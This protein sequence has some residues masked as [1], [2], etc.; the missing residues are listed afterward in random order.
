MGRS[1]PHGDGP[2]TGRSG[3]A[4]GRDCGVYG[5][6]SGARCLLEGGGSWDNLDALAQLA[7]VV[8]EFVV[9]DGGDPRLMEPMLLSVGVTSGSVRGLA[10]MGD[11]AVQP[12]V[13]IVR[14]GEHSAYVGGALLTLGLLAE[15]VGRIPLSTASREE[16]VAVASEGLGPEGTPVYTLGWIVD[17]AA[18]LDDDGLRAI[19]EAMAANPNEV[20]ARLTDP[21]PEHVERI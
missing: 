11:P 14:T 6:S 1:S 7:L 20:A 16:L 12:L 13:D 18:A 10:A 8:S 9:A 3:P 4:R 19:L 5:G 2:E 17:R 15:G 21:E